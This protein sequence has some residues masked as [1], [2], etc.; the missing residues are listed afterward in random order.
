MSNT[1]LREANVAI[2][3]RYIDAINAWDFDTKRA[4][5]AEPHLV[6][7]EHV[8]QL[9]HLDV[10]AEREVRVLRVGQVEGRVKDAEAHCG[11]RSFWLVTDMK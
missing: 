5:L 7:A 3:R 8:V 11:P 6:E 4:L 2:V 10:A 1:E 9:D